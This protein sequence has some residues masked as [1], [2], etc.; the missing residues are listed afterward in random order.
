[1]LRDSFT[2]SIASRRSPA[3]LQRPQKVSACLLAA[4]YLSGCSSLAISAADDQ[5]PVLQ[6]S[7]KQLQ[8]DLELV[9][10]MQI[11]RS[12]NNSRSFDALLE[13]DKQTVQLAILQLNQTIAVLQWDG[14]TLQT[15]LAPGWPQVIPAEQLLSDLQYVW[16]PAQAIAQAM[17]EG[18]RLLESAGTR[19][20]NHNGHNVLL[21]QAQRLDQHNTHI[22]LTDANA[23][24]TVTLSVQGG[25]PSYA[26]T[27][28][29]T[30]TT[31]P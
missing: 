13:A 24:Y 30:S 19:T 20:L 12:G 25:S 8:Q 11:N 3:F 7:P 4:F 22:T 14:D 9:Q 2:P 31:T 23:N 27:K 17:P 18:W 6:L 21:I 29:I 5:R 28:D 26:L 16:W 10:R 15:R 1:M